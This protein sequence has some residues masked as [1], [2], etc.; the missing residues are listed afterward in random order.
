MNIFQIIVLVVLNSGS[1]KG[2]R[3]LNTLY[4]LE[5]GA[6]PLTIGLLLATYAVFPL[7]LAVYAGKVADRHGA[8]LPL[9]AGMIGVGVGIFVP[10]AA[11]S[12]PVLFVSAAVVGLG[13]IFVQV[14]MQAVTG[15]LG[16]GA[17]RT[18]NFNIY[19]L[20]VAS[21]DLVGP[22]VAGFSIDHLGHVPTYL[23]LTLLNAGAVLGL[24]YLIRRIPAAGVRREELRSQRMTDLLG[25][26]ALRR[27]FLG[28]AVVMTGLDLYQLYMPL[29][30][31]AAGLSASVIGILLGAFAAAAFAV[32]V[33]LPLLVRRFGEERT[34]AYSLF[35]AAATFLLFP[36]FTLAIVLGAISFVLGLGLGLGQPLSTILT[37]N[38]SPANRV[39]EALGLRIAINNVMHVAAPAAFGAVGAA[40]GLPVMFW[41]SS[42]LLALGAHAS[43]GPHAG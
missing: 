19:S 26:P 25:N 32:R 18:S 39:G 4:A 10:F 42:A 11:P 2:V 37:Y 40:L 12:L 38:R 13:F 43:R 31:H 22:V 41:V 29:Y 27:T 8:R 5:L 1:F 20:A 28:S 21:S 15:S 16:S 33:M 6:S 30:G 9:L 23:S 17:A 34:L 24:L 14:P 36:F 35:L 3:I 7:F